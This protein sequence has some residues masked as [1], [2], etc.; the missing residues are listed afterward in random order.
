VGGG[1]TLVGREAELATLRR[2]VRDAVDGRG[3]VVLLA[4]EAGVGKSRLA[5]EALSDG[6]ATFVEASASEGGTPP[7]G[8]AVE[9]LRLGFRRRPETVEALGSL[10][11]HL[12]TLLP[13]YGPAVDTGDR[14]TLVEALRA[15]FVALAAGGP[16]AVLLDDLHWAD[17]ATVEL[18]P[19]LAVA[20]DEPLLVVGTYRSDELPRGHPL[21]RVRTELRRAGRLKEVALEPLDDGATNLLAWAAL[22]AEP[23][24][25]LAAAIRDRSLGV[26]FFVE[27]LAAAL[28]ASGR[29]VETPRGLEL[30]EGS[31]LPVPESVR[32]AVLARTDGIDAAARA[33]LEA[34]AVAGTS[35]ELA[36][37]AEL[38]AEQ[39]ID[40]ALASGM[41]VD[42]GSGVAEFRHA[43]ARE[44]VL[45]ETPWIRRRSLHAR[46][47]ELFEAGDGPPE[48]VARHALAAGQ[49]DRAVP[50]LLLAAERFCSVHAYRDAAA[51]VRQALELWAGEEDAPERLDALARLGR[52]LQLSG[53]FRRAAPIWRELADRHARLGHEQA[54][55]TAL[56]DLGEALDYHGRSAEALPILVESAAVFD[57]LDAPGEAARARF[58]AAGAAYGIRDHEAEA[59]LYRLAQ[60]GARAAGDEELRLTA[61][62]FEGSALMHM[63]RLEDGR[64]AVEDALS[65][66][67]SGSYVQAAAD[68]YFALAV[69]LTKTGDPAVQ[70]TLE[71]AIEYCEANGEQAARQ[72]CV[73]CLARVL[74]KTG[75]W[76]RAVEL[77]QSVRAV[78]DPNGISHMHAA[79]AW[80]C[81]EAARGRPRAAKPLL[82]E[83]Q[84]FAASFGGSGRDSLAALGRLDVA[85]GDLDQATDRCRRLLERLPESSDAL[86][87]APLRWAAAHAASRGLA[88]EVAACGQALA[89]IGA[90]RPHV[91]A[92]AALAATLG[93]SLLLARDADGAVASFGQSLALY[94]EIS[95]PF[96]RAETLVRAAAASVAAGQP[97]TAVQQLVE[98]YR[99]SRRLG[100][101]PLAALAASKLSEL[102]ERVDERVGRRG[103]A[104]LRP[105]GL[106][107]RELEVLRLVAVGRTNREIAAELVLSRRTVDMHVRNLLSKL[108]CR[109]RTEAAARAFEE[110][111]LEP[112]TR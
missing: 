86:Y 94:G 8:P 63:G 89:R 80:G 13:E 69:I 40:G 73:G 54:A 6:S 51:V 4:G 101:Q 50:F 72:F 78:P 57:R 107:R 48:L 66:A 36:V 58:L 96:E 5:R 7:Y 32:D 11:P 100:A 27:E 33:A 29:L 61:R 105:G 111:L 9:A 64:R 35:V 16:V 15:A 106:T 103:Q 45:L 83:V 28:V 55:A 91:E 34:A 88:A 53:E 10:R 92:R 74:W 67:L 31:D 12:A 44:A 62:A 68:A 77:A 97:D 81:V 56:R 18:L 104:D 70:A 26:P 39:G 110:R 49:R 65:G 42:T 79:E 38:S 108:D 25:R 52:C 20:R 46:L 17:T 47:S 109:T 24:P 2:L 85:R 22:D 82:G 14:S 1:T 76:D 98:A 87:V 21:R 84:R 37:L 43:L 95:A 99:S 23:G 19:A 60:D 71:Q 90:D 59:D 93:E 102:G 30:P 3:A 75:E 112:A 41:L